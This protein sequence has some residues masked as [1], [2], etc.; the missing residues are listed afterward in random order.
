MSNVV[1]DVVTR[2]ATFHHPANRFIPESR[3]K[4][5]FGKVFAVLSISNKFRP[6]DGTRAHWFFALLI[7]DVSL[8]VFQTVTSAQ[9][10]NSV[11][12]CPYFFFR[13][14]VIKAGMGNARRTYRVQ[15]RDGWPSLL[16]E[17]LL[18]GKKSNFGKTNSHP[19]QQL[20]W[21]GFPIEVKLF[22]STHFSFCPP[23][24]NWQE[25]KL[26]CLALWWPS[27]SSW[28]PAASSSSFPETPHRPGKKTIPHCKPTN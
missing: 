27:Y 18:N 16:P 14:L 13:T 17:F 3:W 10:G 12:M 9:A 2:R 19:R 24:D 22:R 15:E 21:I 26:K 1:D 23:I 5:T 8:R 11:R 28:S 6:A 4:W 20:L 25:R 7:F